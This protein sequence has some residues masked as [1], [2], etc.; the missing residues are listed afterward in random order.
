MKKRVNE[1]DLKN[2]ENEL[3]RNEKSAATIKKYMRDV[4]A[5]AAFASGQAMTK[6]L[7]LIYKRTLTE[8]Y[9]ATQASS[10]NACGG[11]QISRLYQA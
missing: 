3:A 7:V 8:K 9:A 1:S 5:F 10:S 11:E 2:F 4:R 6:E